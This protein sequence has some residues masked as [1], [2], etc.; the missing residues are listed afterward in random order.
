M[1]HSTSTEALSLPS[2]VLGPEEFSDKQ[3]IHC[4]QELRLME[5]AA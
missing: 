1:I 3:S 4:P 5:E 2:T